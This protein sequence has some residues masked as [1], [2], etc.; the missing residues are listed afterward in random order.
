MPS[1]TPD[2][3]RAMQALTELT[4]LPQG[5]LKDFATLCKQTS[6]RILNAGLCPTLAYLKVKSKDNNETELLKIIATRLRPL[7]SG[8][9]T[10]I[11]HR[12]IKTNAFLL[13]RAT[14][15][16]L[17]YLAWLA[18]LAEGRSIQ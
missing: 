11:V 2:Q 8:N 3:M 17:A 16:A 14:D 5:D 13:R 15:E 12:L 9:D 4:A 18:R 1:Q 10:D 7:V 6:T